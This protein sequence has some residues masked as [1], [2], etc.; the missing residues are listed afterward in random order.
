M[1]YWVIRAKKKSDNLDLLIVIFKN[2][3]LWWEFL[4]K[5]PTI[6]VVVSYLMDKEAKQRWAE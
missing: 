4:L 6:L 1:I 3:V 5:L 2:W